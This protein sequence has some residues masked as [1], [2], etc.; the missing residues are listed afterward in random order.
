M[1]WSASPCPRPIPRG[2]ARCL[3]AL[4]QVHGGR[5]R[6]QCATHPDR[7]WCSC[8]S[9]ATLRLTVPILMDRD[10]VLGPSPRL[11]GVLLA[12]FG[13]DRWVWA[14]FTGPRPSSLWP[15]SGANC[16]TGRMAAANALGIGRELRPAYLPRRC[17]PGSRVWSCRGRSRHAP[18]SRVL[19]PWVQA[20]PRQ[21]GLRAL[22]LIPDRPRPGLHHNLPILALFLAWRSWAYARGESLGSRGMGLLGLLLSVHLVR[23]DHLAAAAPRR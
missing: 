11:T 8:M 15:S 20:A 6:F 17:S 5:A 2:D 9:V 21:H 12:D 19:L 1:Q 14:A 4:E 10:F 7:I 16:S 23:G 22:A 13:T 18:G 3:L